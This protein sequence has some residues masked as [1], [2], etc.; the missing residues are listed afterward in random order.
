M[1]GLFKLNLGAGQNF[2][3]LTKRGG[4]ADLCANFPP[5]PLKSRPGL[6]IF[7]QNASLT[8]MKTRIRAQFVAGAIFW[9]AGCA[10]H[11]QE[12]KDEANVFGYDPRLQQ[13]LTAIELIEKQ[14]SGDM[15]QRTGKYV[16]D[17]KA[18]EEEVAKSG[19]L[20]HVIQVRKEREAW[21]KGQKTE[22]FNPKDPEIVLGLR[23][24]RY[25]FDQDLKKLGGASGGKN[26][27]QV[28]KLAAGLTE[29]E[30][31]LTKEGKIEDALAARAAK[32]KLLAGQK[33]SAGDSA[34]PGGWK[35]LFDGKSLAG[36]TPN[37]DGKGNFSV[38]DGAIVVRGGG[39]QLVCTG[40]ELSGDF[41][42]EME[43]MTT[44]DSNSGIFLHT[45]REGRKERDRMLEVAIAITEKAAGNGGYFTGAIWGEA[46]IRNPRIKDGEWVLL[47]VRRR[48]ETVSTALNGKQVAEFDTSS[49]PKSQGLSGGYLS[50]QANTRSGVSGVTHLRKIRIKSL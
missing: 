22:S 9:V 49:S 5:A 31:A 11:A 32:E 42:L 48:G 17:L 7:A 40:H 23:K 6:V 16:A 46:A 21:E 50:L 35:V 3:F 10:L 1:L 2:G 18:L 13:I 38:K 12:E 24:L 4:P 43:V 37:P 26:P 8:A 33:V 36:W 20:N 29:L 34:S 25:Y 44:G 30:T 28:A 15:A 45:G 19:V 27:E 41:E 14:G 39:S 47:Q